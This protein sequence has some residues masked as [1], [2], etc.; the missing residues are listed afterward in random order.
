VARRSEENLK[1][2]KKQAQLRSTFPQQS[3]SQALR[4]HHVGPIAELLNNKKPVAVPTVLLSSSLDLNQRSCKE[5]AFKAG[6]YLLLPCLLAG[7]STLV[8]G[9]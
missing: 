6:S 3:S 2:K 4:T 9:C 1:I 5:R 8:V 7:L